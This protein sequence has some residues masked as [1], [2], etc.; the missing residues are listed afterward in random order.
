MRKLIFLIILIF[1]YPTFALAINI[2][3]AE[4]FYGN[5]AKEI[6]GDK[7]VVTNIISNPNADPH[8]F[9]I[10]AKTSLEISKAQVIIY[11]GAAY[12]KWIEQILKTQTLAVS[13]IINVADITNLNQPNINPHIWYQPSTMPVLATKLT[14]VLI[15]LDSSNKYYYLQNL[16]QFLQENK[17]IQDKIKNIKSNYAKTRVIATEPIYNYMTDSLRLIMEGTDVQWKIMNNTEPSP[18][19]LANYLTLL[20]TRKVKILFYNNQVIDGTTE[21]ILKIA[22]NN[23]IPVIG[24]SETMPENILVNKWLLSELIQTESALEMNKR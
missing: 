14:N 20:N 2:V 7:V 10:T 15:K 3:A 1:T 12:D 23:K 19:M 21:N 13:E 16:N 18:K 17:V 4:N 8:L 22:K 5:L 6:G 9:A 24:I 11:N